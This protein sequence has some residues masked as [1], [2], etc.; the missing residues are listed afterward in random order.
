[1]G[2][3]V[4]RRGEEGEEA[5]VGQGGDSLPAWVAEVVA[6][7]ELA[8]FSLLLQLPGSPTDG[9][10]GPAVDGQIAPAFRR[11]S[12]ATSSTEQTAA[13]AAAGEEEDGGTAAGLCGGLWHRVRGLAGLRAGAGK[14]RLRWENGGAAEV[15]R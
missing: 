10:G 4:R 5:A 12:L 3:G 2:A 7:T 1:M 15:G 8:A 11:R 13:A 9:E 6:L 14:L